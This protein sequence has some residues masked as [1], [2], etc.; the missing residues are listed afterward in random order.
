MDRV[1]DMDLEQERL[2]RAVLRINDKV[3][4]VVFGVIVGTGVFVATL[5]LVVKGGPT[6]GAH[7]SLLSQFFPGYR[8]TYLGSFVGFLYGFLLGYLIGWSIA[9]LYNQFVYLRGRQG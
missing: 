4:G 9:W 8:V 2:V 7:L 6:V 5:W 1:F 3:L